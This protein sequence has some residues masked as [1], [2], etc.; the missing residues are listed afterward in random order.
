MNN[1]TINIILAEDHEFLRDGFSSFIEKCPGIK[2]VA[3]ACDGRQLVQLTEKWLPDV[4]LTDIKMPVMNGI[5]ATKEITKKFP[6]VGVIAF[7]MFNDEYCLNEMLEAGA[8]GYLVKNSSKEEMIAAIN[9]V[10]NKEPFFCSDTKIK[11]ASL[12]AV[13]EEN[14]LT[15][16]EKELVFFICSSMENKEIAEKLY[17]S[18]RTI[19]GYREKIME[20]IKAKKPMQLFVY[21]YVN[22]IIYIDPNQKVHRFN[23]N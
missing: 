18:V 2:L 11:L 19:E 4:V 16:K 17:L 23:P 9:A 21:A 6:T 20:K 12:K 5:E 13:N 10:Y 8:T 3:E 15:E 7:S 1:T 14:Q 22:K